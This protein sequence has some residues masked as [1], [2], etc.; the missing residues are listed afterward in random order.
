[1][2]YFLH[3]QCSNHYVVYAQGIPV[4]NIPDLYNF[5]IVKMYPSP[6][7][8]LTYR[9]IQLQKKW[10]N[11]KKFIHWC[12]HPFRIRYRELYGKFPQYI[13]K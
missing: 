2:S 8:N 13:N 9:I 7:K 6:M 10:R 5:K 4:L 3:K 1:M 12:S 11:W